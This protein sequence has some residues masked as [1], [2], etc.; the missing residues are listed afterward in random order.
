MSNPFKTPEFKK[1]QREWYDKAEEDG[2]FKDIEEFDSPDELL[3]SW[4]LFYKKVDPKTFIARQKY[5]QRAQ[6]IY[7]EHVFKSDI[8]K[9]IWGL[10]S[11]G[12]TIRQIVEKINKKDY[13]RN[14]IFEII[15]AIKKET[16]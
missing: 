16:T 10:H 3:K 5:Y 8:H 7:N 15:R 6:E 12:F 9:E 13:R 14:S 11:Q 4:A 2:S 1:L